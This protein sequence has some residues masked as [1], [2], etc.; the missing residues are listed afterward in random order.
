MGLITHLLGN[1][2]SGG[3]INFRRYRRRGARKNAKSLLIPVRK[4]VCNS[5]IGKC[6][7]VTYY[8]RADRILREQR[9]RQNI[10]AKRFQDRFIG[11]KES[12][13]GL[14]QLF[15]PRVSPQ[16]IAKSKKIW[17]GITKYIYG[18]LAYESGVLPYFER[19]LKNINKQFSKEYRSIK[20]S[21]LIKVI[22]PKGGQ[23][24]KDEKGEYIEHYQTIKV[25]DFFNI[26][27][28]RKIYDLKLDKKN[29]KIKQRVEYEVNIKD[30][31]TGQDYGVQ[32]GGE[33]V[34]D[35]G[36]DKVNFDFIFDKLNIKGF[37]TLE[38]IPQQL[39][40]E[41]FG[42]KVLEFGKVRITNNVIKSL[43]NY[44]L[45]DI[46]DSKRRE[47]IKRFN[48]N[49]IQNLLLS[50]GFSP[51]DLSGRGGINT[52]KF[53]R[54]FISDLRN[55]F[56]NKEFL[57]KFINYYG[58][59]FT[60]N[61]L[62]YIIN[63]ENEVQ[64]LDDFLLYWQKYVSHRFDSIFL[65][66]LAS[67]RIKGL[68][69]LKDFNILG[70]LWRKYWD[71]YIGDKYEFIFDLPKVAS[72]Q[73]E[74]IQ[75]PKFFNSYNVIRADIYMLN[76]YG[77]PYTYLESEL[78]KEHN[79]EA[80]WKYGKTDK[81]TYVDFYDRFIK[82]TIEHISSQLAG[83]PENTIKSILNKI[84]KEIKNN[85]D[86]IWDIIGKELPAEIRKYSGRF[87]LFN[88]RKQKSISKQKLINYISKLFEDIGDKL[89]NTFINTY[90]KFIKS[91][92]D[93]I[94]SGRADFLID[95]AFTDGAIKEYSQNPDQFINNL[96][97]AKYNID[98]FLSTYKL[99]KLFE[100][101]IKHKF[102]PKEPLNIGSELVNFFNNI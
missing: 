41:M 24:K 86:K 88:R 36:A 35:I 6:Y 30:L 93:N 29:N 63:N 3:N 47:E 90:E 21:D 83:L 45:D 84:G 78:A 38:H 102:S 65:R 25:G 2:K 40:L 26:S 5:R 16:R 71:K 51:K 8:V 31:T 75:N 27:I 96:R 95:Y 60:Q 91:I 42:I 98:K 74:F 80:V 11:K 99:K 28:R 100:L 13:W 70:E 19:L 43:E 49:Y 15:N 72:S 34:K 57:M 97:E 53:F 62:K 17:E 79:G 37:K 89:D 56:K 92:K 46:K 77:N 50:F 32:Y 4:R 52:E 61:L 33:F 7:F 48:K 10:L 67:K 12:D 23:K 1:S 44:G 64:S 82:T 9:K 20:E 66:E 39:L 58:L 55:R 81:L 59:E 14:Y 85:P 68:E 73:E 22:N 18:Q 94:K 101:Y 69:F 76:T 54:E 87:S